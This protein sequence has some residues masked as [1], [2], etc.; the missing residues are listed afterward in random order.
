MVSTTTSSLTEE[1]TIITSTIPMSININNAI[2]N[3]NDNLGGIR[4][5]LEET[6]DRYLVD[7]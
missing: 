6:E 1:I 3:N 2:V 7:S 5:Y 4:L